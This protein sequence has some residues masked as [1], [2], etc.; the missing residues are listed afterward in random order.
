MAA[1][2]CR[3]CVFLLLVTSGM[4][5]TITFDQK[6]S[7]TLGGGF[8]LDFTI[9]TEHG[10]S[11]IVSQGFTPPFDSST[12]DVTFSG[13]SFPAGSTITSASLKFIAQSAVDQPVP[14][15]VT[16]ASEGDYLVYPTTCEICF[17]CCPGGC[18]RVPCSDPQ[19]LHDYR[20]G[21]ASFV[22]NSNAFVLAINSTLA[23]WSGTLSPQNINLAGF[24]GDLLA[25]NPITVSLARVSLYSESAVNPGFNA[26]TNFS[27][28]VNLAS[29]EQCLALQVVAETPSDVPE[30]G[31]LTRVALALMVFLCWSQLRRR[32]IPRD[33]DR[34]SRSIDIPK[35]TG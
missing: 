11:S 2:V 22:L 23:S 1:L 24:A 30:P 29:L 25:G 28:V 15:A 14:T 3:V 34:D 10:S 8:P 4:A 31:S 16:V 18:V 26:I 19:I 33:C 27:G 12:G 5:G 9:V 17:P 20:P 35:V 13:Y 7:P 6:F 21:S 32:L